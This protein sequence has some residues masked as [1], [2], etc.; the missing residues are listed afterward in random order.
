MQNIFT[1]QTFN[2]LITHPTTIGYLFFCN[3]SFLNASNKMFFPFVLL[4]LW[5]SLGMKAWGQ[6]YKHFL[7]L[8]IHSTKLLS[9]L[10][11]LPEMGV[12]SA[13]QYLLALSFKNGLLI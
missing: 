10:Q 4:L 5:K 3:F 6:T 7:R 12:L 9:S 8:F 2:D 11:Q 13:S 1:E